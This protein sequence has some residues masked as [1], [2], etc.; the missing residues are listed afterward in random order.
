[1]VIQL[2]MNRFC[3]KLIPI[4]VACKA[5]MTTFEEHIKG[6]LERKFKPDQPKKVS[7]SYKFNLLLSGFSISNAG[8][9][10]NLT[11]NP[12]WITYFK[13]LVALTA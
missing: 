5:S 7:L 10:T 12:F 13:M 3:F 9:I 6:L 1:M 2:Y 8:T 4:E 11:R